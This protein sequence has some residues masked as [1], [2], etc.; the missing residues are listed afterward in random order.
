MDIEMEGALVAEHIR[1][2]RTPHRGEHQQPRNETVV[3]IGS[4]RDIAVELVAGSVSGC[5]GIV[6][7]QVRWCDGAAA[8]VFLYS[9]LQFDEACEITYLFLST[10]RIFSSL[11][12]CNVFVVG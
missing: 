5:A 8:F 3:H 2:N 7:G 12:R 11:R 4:V 1:R 6:V 9:N 10:S